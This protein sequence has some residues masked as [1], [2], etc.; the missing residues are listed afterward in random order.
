MEFW[1]GPYAKRKLFAHATE[2]EDLAAVQDLQAQGRLTLFD[3]ETEPVSG[4]RLI[5]VGG[6]TPGQSIALVEGIGGKALLAADAVHFSEEQEQ[7]WPFLHLSS[8][9]D[10]YRTFDTIDELI[11]DGAVLVPGHDPEVMRRF[12]AVPCMEGTAVQITGRSAD[13]S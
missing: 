3:D 7:Q 10:V 5:E 4:V 13:A 1:T 8:L 12:P 6:H 2:A 9:P 11:R